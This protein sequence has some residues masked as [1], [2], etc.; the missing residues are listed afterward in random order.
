MIKGTFIAIVMLLVLSQLDQHFLYG[1]HT[2][3]ARSI[4]RQ[5]RHS[6]G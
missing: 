6:F 2:D 1:K 4:L 3:A 5:M